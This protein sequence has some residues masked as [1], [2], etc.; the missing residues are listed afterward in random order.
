MILCTI[1]ITYDDSPGFQ[2]ENNYEH[3]FGSL[4]CQHKTLH[5]DWLLRLNIPKVG[6]DALP[7]FD[8]NRQDLIRGQQ[9]AVVTPVSQFN[10][11]DI[12]NLGHT[13]RPVS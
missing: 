9:E 4:D 6:L 1:I 7:S 10:R 2:T 13:S 8:S 11:E 5:S 12:R 3:Y